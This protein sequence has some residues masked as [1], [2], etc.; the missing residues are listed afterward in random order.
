MRGGSLRVNIVLI[1]NEPDYC[2]KG[3]HIMYR[4]GS[5]NGKWLYQCM[6]CGFMETK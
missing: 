2:G 4:I 5:R 6:D 3:V 1:D